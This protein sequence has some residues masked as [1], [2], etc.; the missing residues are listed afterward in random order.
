[1]APPRDRRL[2]TR[3]GDRP[4]RWRRFHLEYRLS[5]NG[6]VLHVHRLRLLAGVGGVTKPEL[7]LESR[8]D[9]KYPMKAWRSGVGGT[10]LLQIIVGEDGR[11]RAVSVMKSTPQRPDFETA[12]VEAVQRWRYRP[13]RLYGDPV[14]VYLTV[15]VGF[16]FDGG[17]EERETTPQPARVT[18]R[19]DVRNQLRGLRGL[20]TLLTTDMENA[21]LGEALRQ[22]GEVARIRTLL[23]GSPSHEVCV[24]AGQRVEVLLLA[25]AEEVKLRYEV[26]DEGFTVNVFAP[27]LPGLDGVTAPEPIREGKREPVYPKKVRRARLD[28]VVLLKGIVSEDGI[29]PEATVVRV[30]PPGLGF[31]KAALQAVR[32]WRYWPATREGRPVPVLLLVKVDFSMP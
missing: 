16:H 26:D 8:V 15:K 2:R 25:L 22:I 19:G 1:M 27:W 14:P 31:E 10:V 3:R 7:I 23:V 32:H 17:R 29:V 9:P 4:S 18:G 12:A 21:P 20:D 30:D 24:R 11:L 6:R 5:E 13:A 28:G